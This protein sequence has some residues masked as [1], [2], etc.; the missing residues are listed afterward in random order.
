M[1]AVQ[2]G[3]VVG[4]ND[5]IASRWGPRIVDLLQTVE[6]GVEEAS[7]RDVSTTLPRHDVA[8]VARGRRGAP[9][10]PLRPVSARRAVVV[11]FGPCSVRACCSACRWARPT[12]RSSTALRVLASHL[13]LRALPLGREPHRRRHPVADPASQGGARRPGRRHAGGGRGRLPGS[14]PQPAGR[15]LPARGGRRRRTGGHRGHR[16]GTGILELLPLAAFGGAVGAVTLTYVVGATVGRQARGTAVDRAGRGGRRRPAHRHPDVPAAAARPGPPGGVRVDPRQPD[17]GDVVRRGADPPLC[18]HQRR[19]P[20]RPPAT[21]RRAPGRR[22]RGRQPRRA[23]VAR[24]A[25]PSWRP[26]PSARPRRW[27]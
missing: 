23:V 27:R 22:G 1:T 26:P 2:K 9:D 25:S 3:Q 15:P 18:R 4:L 6:S 10:A 5:D 11:A 24:S 16:G 21:P 12:C 13:P 14:V 20:H 19:R 8:A 17:G 7:G